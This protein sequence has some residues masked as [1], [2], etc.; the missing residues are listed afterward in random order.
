VLTDQPACVSASPDHL[1]RYVDEFSFRHNSRTVLGIDD[2]QRTTNVLA[3][4]EGK[5]LTY[6]QAN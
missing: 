2:Q 6:R 1:S 4:I 3:G 5:R